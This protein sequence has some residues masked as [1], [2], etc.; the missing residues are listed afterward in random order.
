MKR[1][2][3]LVIGALLGF[4]LYINTV[5]AIREVPVDFNSPTVPAAQM[6]CSV[7]FRPQEIPDDGSWLQVCLLDPAAPDDSTV[8]EVNVKY[9]LDHLAPDQLEVRLSRADGAMSQPLWERG[10][11]VDGSEFGKATGLEAFNGT[12]AQGG[13]YF[14]VRDV[15]PG[16]SGWLREVSISVLYAPVGPLP[17]QVSGAPGRPTSLRIPPEVVKITAPGVDEKKTEG[18]VQSLTLEPDG[19][20]IIM[21]EHFERVFP[22]S[23]GWTLFDANPNDG[24]EYLW[25]DDDYRHQSNGSWAGWPANGGA[26]GLDPAV[27]PYPPNAQSWMIYGPFDLSNAT[28]ATAAEVTFWLWRQIEITYDYLYFGASSDGRNFSGR[29]WDGTADWESVRFYLD[30]Y[31]AVVLQI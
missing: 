23:T 27:S 31:L 5:Q 28:G 12:A 24:R 9:R 21:F 8:T 7:Q 15:V 29:W 16:Q 4:G 11:L 10:S 26:D 14:W 22:P 6:P 1:S 30:N 2:L 25:D 20:A 17:R 18:K 19:W 13:W 3:G